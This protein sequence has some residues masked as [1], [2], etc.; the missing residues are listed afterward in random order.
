[1][2]IHGRSAGG[3]ICIDPPGYKVPERD[4]YEAFGRTFS[5]RCDFCNF[6]YEVVSDLWMSVI[7]V[8]TL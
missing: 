8:Q 3:G 2:V 7:P 5:S 4:S 6:L 1:M